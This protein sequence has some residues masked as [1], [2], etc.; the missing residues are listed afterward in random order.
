MA[1]GM[2]EEATLRH[3]LTEVYP[4]GIFS[5]VSDTWD[6]WNL[7]TETLPKLKP[8]IMA[9]AGKFVVRPDSSKKTPVEVLCGDPEAPMDSPEYKGLV[10]LLWEIFGGVINS[11]GFKQL[12]PHIGAIYG[13]SITL[14][15]Q[16]QILYQ[17][18]AKGFSS[19]NIVL[20]IGSYT[21]QFV[22]RDTHGFAFKATAMQ[23]DNVDTWIPIFKDPKTSSTPKKS[24]KGLLAVVQ[25][26]HDVRLV[27]D[28]EDNLDLFNSAENLLKPVVFEPFHVI[29][30]RVHNH[31]DRVVNDWFA[32]DEIKFLA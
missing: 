18:R 14:E 4:T 24:A 19:T 26:A 31:T 9:R 6:F 10:E 29:R 8:E 2:D 7:V 28:C 20:G 21:Y 32:E 17:L 23:L 27:Q 12:D 25:D 5:Y 1:S 30:E 13:D 15:Y 3:L 16:A 11:K 22:T